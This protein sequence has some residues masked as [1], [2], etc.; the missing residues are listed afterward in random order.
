MN[1]K[2]CGDNIAED[3]RDDTL[4]C[5]QNC[6][7]K[8]Y[9]RRK[10]IIDK[11]EFLS[12][13]I[14]S[15]NE[16]IAHWE[17]KVED[18]KIKRS[19]EI[20][21]LKVSIS[22]KTKTLK[23]CKTVLTFNTEDFCDHLCELFESNPD[24]Y[25]REIEILDDENRN[26]FKVLSSHRK[27]YVRS[28]EILE[29]EIKRLETKLLS[30]NFETLFN[31]KTQL[32]ERAIKAIEKA[33]NEILQFEK[34][35]GE[36]QQIDIDRLP[37]IAKRIKKH[38]SKRISTSRAY[39]GNEIA[40][41]KFEH[42]KLKGELGKFLGNLERNKCAIA[43]T[44]DSGAGKSTFSFSLADGFVE[45]DKSVG[46]FSLESGFTTKFKEYAK[47]HR[48][49]RNFIAFEEG[50]LNDV[51]TEAKNFDCIIIDSYSKVSQKAADFEALRQDFPDTFFIIIFQKTTDGKIRG[52]SSI[53]F[54]STATIDVQIKKDGERIAVMK[55]SRYDTENFI[56]SIERGEI[57]KGDKRPIKWS[58]I[59]GRDN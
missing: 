47:R 10:K 18:E 38:E 49:N 5:D 45:L 44:G 9:K 28:T 58:E 46:Y 11:I 29:A 24:K 50:T 16:I 17:K 26:V 51:R 19:G 56:Y 32:E 3:K 23:Y 35:L 53:L 40:N 54:N 37:A 34:E 31:N 43:L 57:L 21:K 41:L 20:Q 59:E 27:R 7:Q 2:Q 1:C 15:E 39:S 22:K 48:S 14:N 4:F 8:H 25:W 33:Q 55:K 52:G 36:L 12:K 30:I 6:K 13:A 42:V